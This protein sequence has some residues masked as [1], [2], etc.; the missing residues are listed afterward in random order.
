MME[1]VHGQIGGSTH[2][3]STNKD[4]T[5]KN[6]EPEDSAYE[7]STHKD[8]THENSTHKD[9][10]HDDSTHDIWNIKAAA[11]PSCFITALSSLLAGSRDHAVIS[12]SPRTF[13]NF[14][15]GDINQRASALWSTLNTLA[16]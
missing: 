9:S 13:R 2:E 6:S 1:E 7:D 12:G 5:H 4:S 10:T 14:F 11:S 3:N 16:M 15:T 8:S